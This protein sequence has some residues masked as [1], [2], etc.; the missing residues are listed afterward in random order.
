MVSYAL[1]V[2]KA[3]FVVNVS[4]LCPVNCE[5]ISGYE[6][7]FDHTGDGGTS[8]PHDHDISV[9]QVHWAGAV[10]AFI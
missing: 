8:G 1:D 10:V 9:N 3:H 7:T 6:L 2:A 4:W 5:L